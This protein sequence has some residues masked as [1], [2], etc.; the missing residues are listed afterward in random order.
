MKKIAFIVSIAFSTLIFA[1]ETEKKMGPP[2]GNALVG[3]VYG[4]SISAKAEKNAITPKKLDKKLAQSKK[5]EN[6]AVK[7]KVT[8]VCEKKGC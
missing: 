7:G 4:S 6:V 1:Q 2:A 3:D 5:L 8:D